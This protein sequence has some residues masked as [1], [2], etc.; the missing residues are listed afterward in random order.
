ME[1]D[2]ECDDSVITAWMNGQ[3]KEE[4]TSAI[5]VAATGLSFGIHLHCYPADQWALVPLSAPP[6]H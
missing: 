3:V 2:Y 4:S 5:A 1:Q 6:A